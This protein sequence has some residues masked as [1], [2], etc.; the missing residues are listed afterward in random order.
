MPPKN[1]KVNL[2]LKYRKM[3]EVG[4]I[5]SLFLIIGAFRY[6]PRIEY[7]KNDKPHLQD[8]FNLEDVI[9]TGIN[10]KPHHH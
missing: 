5:I 1:P 7:A 2:K 4:I 6:F 3:F 9:L 8:L 10:Q